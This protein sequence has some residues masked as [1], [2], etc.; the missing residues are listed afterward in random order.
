M[1]SRSS[2]PIRGKLCHG[3]CP[4]GTAKSVCAEEGQTFTLTG[5]DT[6][7]FGKHL[8]LVCVRASASAW[9]KEAPLHPRHSP[10]HQSQWLPEASTN[11]LHALLELTRNTSGNVGCHYV[12]G[13]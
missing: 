3:P 12:N 4:Q 2:G 5:S 6:V 13:D 10:K 7:S 9:Y 8:S 11:S 1:M